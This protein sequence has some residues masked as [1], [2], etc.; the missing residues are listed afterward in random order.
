MWL[1]IL[2]ELCVHVRRA[3]GYRVLATR[4]HPLLFEMASH[5]SELG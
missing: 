3:R 4:K 5:W 1:F 2:L